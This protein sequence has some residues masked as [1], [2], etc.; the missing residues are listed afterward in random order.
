MSRRNTRT[1]LLCTVLALLILLPLAS[2]GSGGEESVKDTSDG[3]SA[4]GNTLSSETEGA[5]S[6]DTDAETEDPRPAPEC[7]EESFGGAEYRVLYRYGAVA[8]NCSDIV[9]EGI[10][11]E[12]INDAVYNR[13]LSLEDTLG[14]KLCAIANSSPAMFVQRDIRSGGRE[15][16]TVA[17]SMN[18]LYPLALSG[19]LLDWRTLPYFDVS[20][21]WWDENSASEM[22]LGGR[23]FMMTGDITMKTSGC[24]RFLNFN[25]DIW[26]RYPLPDPYSLVRENTWTIDRFGSIISTVSEDLDGN[27]TLDGHDLWGLLADPP[28]F[29]LAGCG[30][31]YTSKDENDLPYID[32]INE[33][34]VTALEKL[35]AV[36]SDENHVTDYAKFAKGMNTSS[37]PHI[38]DY[39]RARFA[40]GQ[41]MVIGNCA[42]DIRLQI[43]GMEDRY[44]ILPTPKLDENQAEYYHLIDANAPMWGFSSNQTDVKLASAATEVWA[45][46]SGDLVDAFYEVTMKKKRADMPE[47]AEMLDLVRSSVRY[48][49]TYVVDVGIS[50]VITKAYESGNLMST[51]QKQQKLISKK[52]GSL[53]KKLGALE[54]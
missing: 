27:G 7:A 14:V 45:Y 25:K 48:E 11:G 35:K 24:V 15:F 41:I 16:D 6:T 26:D 28:E 51:Y 33:H 19:C 36:L 13:N 42:D 10:N 37:Y 17:E 9:A 8:Y 20:A 29:M 46:L 40:A 32:C 47:D 49:I 53:E 1:R 23:I 22:S 4:P 12:P 39:A 18:Q 2:C 34:T 50:G 52:L 5:E 38:F 21:P 3:G 31:L 43:A 54:E 30:V 44:G